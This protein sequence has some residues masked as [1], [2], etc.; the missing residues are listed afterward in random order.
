MSTLDLQGTGSV[1]TAVGRLD[2]SEVRAELKAQEDEQAV[3]VNV[4]WYRGDEL[5]RRDGWVNVKCG[6]AANGSTGRT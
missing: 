6:A 4:E 2:R 1:D 3:Y 5:V